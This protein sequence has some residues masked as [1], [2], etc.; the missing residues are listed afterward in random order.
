M[1]FPV[2]ACL[3]RVDVPSSAVTGAVSSVMIRGMGVVAVATTAERPTT[4]GE[5]DAHASGLEE[6]LIG[7]SASGFIKLFGRNLRGSTSR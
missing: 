6:I 2:V 5:D 4:T 1:P 3:S 7:H